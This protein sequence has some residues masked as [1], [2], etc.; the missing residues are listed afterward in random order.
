MALPSLLGPLELYTPNT[1]PELETPISGDPFM[2]LMAANLNQTNIQS[3][4]PPMGFTENGSATF[5]SSDNPCLDFFFHIVP[6]T[7]PL[8]LTQKIQRAWTLN[9][10]TTLKLICF[11]TVALWLFNYH[12]RT[13]AHNVESFSDFEYFK[14]LPEILFQLLKGPDVRKLQKAEW[15]RFKKSKSKS[16]YT[17]KP[18]ITREIRVLNTEERSKNEKEN[19]RAL[20]EKKRVAMAKKVLLYEKI[21]N[22]FA[23]CLKSNIGFLNSK[24]LKKISLAAKWCPSIDSSFDHSTLLCES[25][26]KKVFPRELYPEYET[27]EEAHYAYRVRDRLRKQ[28][29]VPLRKVYIG[30]NKWNE[31]PYERVASGKAKIA[32]GALLPHD[33]IA[34]LEDED[35]WLV[36]ELQWKRMVEHLVKLGKMR[37]CLAVSDV[38]GSM[39]EIPMEASVALGLRMDWGMNTDFQK[40]FDLI[41]GV[42]VNGKLK[43]EHMVKR[44]FVFSN[45]EFD[46]ASA[47]GWE[48]KFGEKGY[49]SAVPQI[50]FWNLRDLRATLV[51]T[52]EKWVA[53]LSGFSKN[54]L[55]IFLDNE[56]DIKPE[57][58]ME[59]AISGV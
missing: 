35:G 45:M 39:F 9:P 44:L 19:E 58:I 49:G 20:R 53:L 14:D 59:A 29:L 24:E 47:N 23:E 27:I 57:D 33:I 38:S 28:V 43:E 18:A 56:G 51:P 40:V 17:F 34:S 25:I 13:L 1:K 46:E 21:S 7:P 26:A 10:Q 37:N 12:P 8:G 55:K 41:L 22:H 54:L 48:T 2:D 36:R 16:K 11:Y 30:A 42:A 4:L 50:V 15:L 5:L 32:A 6:D 3:S 52:T 31:I